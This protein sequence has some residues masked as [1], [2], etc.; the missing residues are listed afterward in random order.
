LCSGGGAVGDRVRRR[1]Q[2]EYFKIGNLARRVACGL[3]GGIVRERGRLPVGN[4]CADPGEPA[5][6]R[7]EARV[8]QHPQ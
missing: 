3:A 6:R 1:R 5:L 7:D 2:A 8:G 4:D